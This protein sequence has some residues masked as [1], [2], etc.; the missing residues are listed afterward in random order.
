MSLFKYNKNIVNSSPEKL[1]IL[2]RIFI[3]RNP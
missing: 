2:L 3:E 1:K